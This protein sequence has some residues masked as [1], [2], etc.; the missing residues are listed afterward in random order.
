M[1]WVWPKTINNFWPEQL[2]WSLP[3]PRMALM[4][5]RK[6][7]GP[8][9][10]IAP[11]RFEGGGHVWAKSSVWLQI[12]RPHLYIILQEGYKITGQWGLIVV[13]VFWLTIVF[14]ATGAEFGQNHACCQ[15]LSANSRV[16]LSAGWLLQKASMGPIYG[17]GKLRTGESV[18]KGKT[19]KHMKDF[20]LDRGS[21]FFFPN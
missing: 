9:W 12:K 14:F 7:S 20:C 13:E 10:S 11:V 1:F 2:F 19:V 3:K 5:R 18:I 16:G 15:R 21:F 6:L 4:G 8:N 17:E